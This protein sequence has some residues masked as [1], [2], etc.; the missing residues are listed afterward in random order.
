MLLITGQERSGTTLFA[1]ALSRCYPVL[2][3][4]PWSWEVSY[5]VL[6]KED[7]IIDTLNTIPP[8]YRAIHCPSWVFVARYLGIQEFHNVVFFQRDIRDQVCSLVEMMSGTTQV[9]W[10]NPDMIWQGDHGMWVKK[11]A[12]L[13]GF[14]LSET[15][16]TL[17]YL[18]CTYTFAGSNFYC[19]NYEDFTSSALQFK[20]ILNKVGCNLSEE[21]L[22]LILSK[23]AHITS[24]PIRGVGRWRE[25][26]PVDVAEELIYWKN[27]FLERWSYTSPLRA[28]NCI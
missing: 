12:P 27:V 11:V 21:E 13:L 6:N 24:K 10:R 8:N 2:Q 14:D 5:K 20:M 15:I 22:R 25:D 1:K 16:K 4:S 9:D 18:W 23:Q 19:I 28:T 17:S 3:D 26:L 7:Q